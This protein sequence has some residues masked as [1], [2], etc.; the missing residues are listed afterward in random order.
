MVFCVKYIIPH[1]LR[2]L[3]ACLGKCAFRRSYARR[4]EALE[5][6]PKATRFA[7][8]LGRGVE[9]A[10]EKIEGAIQEIGVVRP[11][12]CVG[13]GYVRGAGGNGGTWGIGISRRRFLGDRS[14]TERSL[15]GSSG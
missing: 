14:G 2:G 11:G 6:V 15:A 12:E 1:I 9:F 3:R 5:I 10:V 13:G 8:A 7:L 4:R